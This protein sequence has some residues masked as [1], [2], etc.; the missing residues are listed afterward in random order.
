[1]QHLTVSGVRPAPPC[2]V[3]GCVTEHRE[4]PA[5][6]PPDAVEDPQQAVAR[7]R[8]N[9][10]RGRGPGAEKRE[11]DRYKRERPTLGP[12][13]AP[14]ERELVHLQTARARCGHARGVD[15]T[16]IQNQID[17][18]CEVWLPKPADHPRSDALR[19]RLEGLLAHAS[20]SAVFGSAI[21]RSV[22]GSR[23]VKPV[24]GNETKTSS[25]DGKKS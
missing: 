6:Q 5:G 14:L 17:R 21:S 2:G 15:A 23:R 8:E 7:A 18:L 11:T 10:L 24:A 13:P 16:A 20:S 1:M 22:T 19:H 3:L 4:P 25:G 12:L 9:V